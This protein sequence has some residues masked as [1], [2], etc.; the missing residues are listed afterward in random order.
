MKAVAAW[1]VLLLAVNASKTSH[2]TTLK[3]TDTNFVPSYELSRSYSSCIA[4]IFDFLSLP[5]F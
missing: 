4:N 5:L 3:I 2:L 1:H